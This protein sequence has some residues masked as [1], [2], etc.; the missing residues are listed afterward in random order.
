[1][2]ILEAAVPADAI[3]FGVEIAGPSDLADADLVVGADG[4]NSVIREHVVGRRIEAVRLG[5]SALIGSAPGAT[6]IVAETWGDGCLFGITPRNGDSANWFAA[7]RQHPDDPVPADPV[8]FLEATY[9]D[10]HADIR[11]L[12]SRID[13]SSI[14]SYR[15][16]EM[17]RLPSYVRDRV[18]LLGDAA[19]CMAP[20][21]G[22]G[23]CEAIIDGVELASA[24]DQLGV[25]DGLPRY[26]LT[27]RPATQ[28]LVAR[29]RTLSRVA[30]ATRLVL[31]RN[32][33]LWTIGRFVR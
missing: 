25:A 20:N 12:L 13:P 26:D 9:G 1:M 7:F 3:S 15:A 21:I 23:A 33:V 30:L 17:P 18:A 27:R 31:V 10:W 28:K 4:V 29:S 11:D 8:E 24:V 19:H 5:F 2:E 32:G 14:L 6:D 22:R 16:K